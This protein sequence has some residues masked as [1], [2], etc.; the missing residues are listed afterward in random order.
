M[1]AALD[2]ARTQH[3]QKTAEEIVGL[4]DAVGTALGDSHEDISLERVREESGN[5]VE[6]ERELLKK[7]VKGL[8]K[9]GLDIFFR[10]VQA[11]WTE[12]Y[13]FVDGRTGSALEKFGLPGDAEELRM[14]L[15]EKWSELDVGDVDVKDED[16][17]K[18]R[19]FV[20]LLERAVGADLEGNIDD[21]KAE[22]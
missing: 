4:A 2:E 13:P 11:V 17:K 8:G 3:R 14:L 10:R 15:E 16:E 5:D 9:T 12:V 22:A 18:R 6:R 1:R 19:V 7:S 20:R 21:V